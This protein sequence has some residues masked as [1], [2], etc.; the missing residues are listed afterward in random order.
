MVNTPLRGAVEV[1]IEEN[2]TAMRAIVVELGDDRV[3]T[4]PALP[5]ANSPFAI[6][7]HCVGMLKFWGGSVIGGERIPRDRASEFTATG[8]VGALE[9]AIDD[10]A[11][12]VGGWVHIALTEGPRDRDAEGSTRS[13]DVSSRSA[14]WMLLHIIRELSQHLG[15]LELSRD[16]LVHGVG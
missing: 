1:L 16:I 10:V 4:V 12:R 13:S 7:F 6:V 3:N 15:Q 14:E 5:G 2:L 8:T 11:A 9:S